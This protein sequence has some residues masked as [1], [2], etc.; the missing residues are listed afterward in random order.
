[1]LNKRG[2]GATELLIIVAVGLSIVLIFIALNFDLLGSSDTRLRSAKSRAILDQFKEAGQLVY[3]QGVGSRIKISISV[4]PSV[5]NFTFD[6]QTMIV[7]FKQSGSNLYRNLGFPL[8]GDIPSE[9][10]NYLITVEAFP[11]S[12]NFFRTDSNNPA[13]VT[14]LRNTSQ[15]T[16]WITWR[17]TNPSDSDF[18][19]SDIYLDGAL[20]GDTNLEVYNA[21]GLLTN[22]SYMLTLVPV[23][24]TGNQNNTNVSSSASTIYP[25]VFIPTSQALKTMT[26]VAQ[27]KVNESYLLTGSCDGIYPVAC[28]V[29]ADLLSCDD[30]YSETHLA[31]RVN[32]SYSYGGIQT[33]YF[34]A[35]VN[36]CFN[37][38]TVK[39]C[40]EWWRDAALQ[41]CDISVDA[42][43]GTNFSVASS[44]CPGTS[45]PGVTCT[46]VT[47]LEDWECSNFFGSSGTRAKARSE[48]QRSGGKGTTIISWDNFY[49]N[50]SYN[51]V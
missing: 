28:G 48:A 30:T 44:T 51:E 17:W 9:E 33:T 1:M 10:G 22:T 37:I 35:T 11:D 20:V 41:N 14:N 19:K 13:S 49:F 2:Q 24:Y 46:D 4:P 3:R 34:N 5:E 29:N 40:H 45:P 36:N 15:G 27:D 23:D 21:T 42:D 16:T 43:G 26:C 32:I 12:V 8:R 7:N 50:V 25:T 6:N 47:S 39:L 18:S 31:Q 38:T